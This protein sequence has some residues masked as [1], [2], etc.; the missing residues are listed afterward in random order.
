MIPQS[1]VGISPCFCPRL[2]ISALVCETGNTVVKQC[3]Q[4]KYSTSYMIHDFVTFDYQTRRSIFAICIHPNCIEA[5]PTLTVVFIN[6]KI[7]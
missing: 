4:G 5:I 1:E 2:V 6:L 7:K 3:S